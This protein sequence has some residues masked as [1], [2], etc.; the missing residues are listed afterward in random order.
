MTEPLN[1]SATHLPLE[2]QVSQRPTKL[3]QSPYL[4]TVPCG[5]PRARPD[6]VKVGCK[7]RS[8][9]FLGLVTVPQGYESLYFRSNLSVRQPYQARRFP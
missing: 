3:C 1:H 6:E 2:T 9:R 5:D 7:H 4:Q 8:V